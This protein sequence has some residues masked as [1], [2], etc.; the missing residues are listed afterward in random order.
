MSSRKLYD[1]IHAANIGRIASG[2]IVLDDY[3]GGKLPDSRVGVS[4][5]I[6]ARSFAGSYAKLVSSA[7]RAEPW[8]YYYPFHDLHI[9]VFDFIRGSEAYR[10]DARL[11]KR[12]LD[13]AREAARSFEPFAIRF[14]GIVFSDA[15]GLIQGYDDDLLARLRQA[16]RELMEDAGLANDERYRSES[17]HL[18]FARF[19]S[20]LASPGG[21]REFI[22]GNR[23]TEI[24]RER[25]DALELVEHDWYDRRATRRIIGRVE[26]RGSPGRNSADTAVSGERQA[27]SAIAPGRRDRYHGLSEA[28]VNGNP[29]VALLGRR[30]RLAV[31]GGGAG[32]FIG[33]MHRMAARLDDRYELAAGV[34]SSDPAKALE[35]G[36][37]LGLPAG[38]AYGSV[39]AMLE[40]EARREDRVDV[41]AIMTPNDSHFEYA[42]AALA[43][44]Y[45]V[46]CDKPM[47]NTLAEAETLHRLALESGR[48]FCLTHNYTGY[49]MVRQ[50][51]A[52]VEAGQLGTVR[53][54]QVEYVQ[55]GK[56]DESDPSGPKLPWRYDP[57]RGGPSLVLGDIGTHAHNLLRF[58]SR[59]EV[60]ELAAEAGA[61]V[62]GRKVHDYAGALL[63]LSGGARG[64]FWVTQAAAGVE[65]CLRIRVSGT[66]GSLEWQQEVP[67]ELVFK[68]LSG[69]AR[70]FTPGGPELLPLARRSSRIVKGHPEGFPEAFAN[71]YSDA[72]EAIAARIAGKKPDPLALYFPSSADGLAGLRFVAAAVESSARGGA[73]IKVARG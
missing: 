30:L 59:L 1:A 10:P 71:L 62:P 46:I 41:V 51:A 24:G 72:A 23:E 32:S 48:V 67:Q 4:L 21:L 36:R 2:E 8:Q 65:N 14:S 38:R 5:V 7:R 17:A 18:T 54:V 68:P 20:P 70:I 69:S 61:V 43:A 13:L 52:M 35:Q 16:I 58:I 19:I 25:V 31:V 56:A 33:G 73:W 29:I 40:A 28:I 53:L 50:A 42:S 55:G 11:E 12:F 6:S 44:G 60:E 49:P 15:A 66:R 27:R 26:L 63:R 45:D 22:D 39:A 64:S 3:L 34:L 57:M 9:T 47:T 37:E